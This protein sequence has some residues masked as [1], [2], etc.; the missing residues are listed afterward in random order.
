MQRILISD[1]N[2]KSFRICSFSFLKDKKDEDYVK[3]SFPDLKDTKSP[4]SEDDLIVEFSTHFVAGISHFKTSDQKRV[5]RNESKS[6]FANSQL[7]HLLTYMVYDL[8]HF[9]EFTKKT[10][11]HDYVI[12]NKFEITK[13]KVFEFYLSKL[14]KEINIP[15]ITYEDLEWRLY[16]PF[17]SKSR[18]YRM[19]MIEYDFKEKDPKKSGVSLFR[20]HE[21]RAK[22]LSVRIPKL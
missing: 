10:E 13:G 6:K 7:I 22:H 2:G 9:K 11:S 21:Q 19:L 4:K 15:A 14:T 20:Q 16:H 3:F 8:N 1:N 17:E 18:N 12:S 5:H